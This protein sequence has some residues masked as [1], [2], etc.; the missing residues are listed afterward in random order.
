MIFWYTVMLTQELSSYGAEI[1][2]QDERAA[3][4]FGVTGLF[5]T[6]IKKQVWDETSAR[7][8]VSMT[9]ERGPG[10]ENQ[11]ITLRAQ[12]IT[13]AAGPFSTPH[14]PNLPGLDKFRERKPIMH[15][16]RWDWNLVGGC[17]EQPDMVNLRDKRVAVIGTGATAV[18]IIPEVAKWAKH[19]YVIQRTPSYIG[20][21]NQMETTDYMWSK[22]AT[23]KGWQR[24]RMD[25]FDSFVSNVPDPVDQIN[26]GVSSHRIR[27]FEPLVL[28]E[29]VVSIGRHYD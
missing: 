2:G 28:S 5:S 25:H 13:H 20:P 17:Q 8:I 18:Q 1:R 4:H 19:L 3:A 23:G 22:V 9:R 21:R 14:I 7:W 16:A 27:P 10:R 11:D 15:S 26:D 29:I 6:V 12:F 24:N